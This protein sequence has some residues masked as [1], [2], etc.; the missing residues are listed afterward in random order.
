MKY[1]NKIQD[2]ID[3][4]IFQLFNISIIDIDNINKIEKKYNIRINIV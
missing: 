4:F 3:Q 1:K 2:N